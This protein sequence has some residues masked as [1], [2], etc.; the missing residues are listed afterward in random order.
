MPARAVDH[1]RDHATPTGDTGDWP[2][3][4]PRVAVFLESIKLRRKVNGAA[5]LYKGLFALAVI[6]IVIF[7]LIGMGLMLGGPRSRSGISAFTVVPVMIIAGLTV[8][9]FFA[10]RATVRSKR[11]APATML[12]L[13]LL[14]AGL[15][16]LNV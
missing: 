8:L 9:Y 14:L 2:L 3:D 10:W 4:D 12:G 15:N 7:G 16:L 5:Q 13:F 11:W 6:A 1:L